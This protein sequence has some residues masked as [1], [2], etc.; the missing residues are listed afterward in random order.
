MGRLRQSTAEIQALLD[1]IEEGGTGLKYSEERTVYL[2][3]IDILG[4]AGVVQISEEE[5]AYNIE[6][7]NKAW[8]N[9]NVFISWFGVYFNLIEMYNGETYGS[10]TFNSLAEYNDTLVSYIIKVDTNGD[11]IATLKEIQTGG[12]ATSDF[13][14]DFNNDF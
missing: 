13:N 6:T 2:T 10:A 14:N 4:E 3:E 11:A 12:S 5:R 9:N 8:D 7:F 1:K